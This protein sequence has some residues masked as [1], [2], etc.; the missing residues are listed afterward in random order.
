MQVAVE[1]EPVTTEAARILAEWREVWAAAGDDGVV[2]LA[3]A[4]SLAAL[5]DLKGRCY[6][7]GITINAT[8]PDNQ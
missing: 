2:D 4:Y 6:A 5:L 3:P 7:Y 8:F 1:L